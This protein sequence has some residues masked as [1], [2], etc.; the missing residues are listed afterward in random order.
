[1]NAG[2]AF[3]LFMDDD[4]ICMSDMIST[5]VGIAQRMNADLV[6]SRMVLFDGNALIDPARTIPSEIF[7]PLGPDIGA[8]AVVNC[9]GDANMLISR[10]AFEQLGGFPEDYGYSHQDWEFY[11]KAAL[12]G[13]KLETIAEPL[14]WYRVSSKSMI[15]QRSSAAFDFRRHIRPYKDVLPPELFRLLQ[16]TQG[17][18]ERRDQPVEPNSRRG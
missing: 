6:T 11:A 17:L 15:R 10:T 4:N 7:A 16:L 3:F 2:G 8:G 5:Y 18:V 14:F 13:M 1:M 9:F 12:A